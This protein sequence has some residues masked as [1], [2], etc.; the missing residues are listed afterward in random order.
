[1]DSQLLLFTCQFNLSSVGD[2]KIQEQK[3]QDQDAGRKNVLAQNA[4]GKCRT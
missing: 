3:M 1:M 2:P 4:G